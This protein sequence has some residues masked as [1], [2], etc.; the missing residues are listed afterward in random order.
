LEYVGREAAGEVQTPLTG[1][2]AAGLRVGD[3][4]WFRHTKS[5][6]LSEHVASFA[7]IE[8]GRHV[9]DVPSYRGEGRVFL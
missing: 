7:L 8:G 9:G 2:A 4:V 6:E 5:G 1:T 3:R